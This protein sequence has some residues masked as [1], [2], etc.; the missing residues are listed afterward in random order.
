MSSA[1]LPVLLLAASLGSGYIFY[2]C[3]R[4]KFD[5]CGTAGFTDSL[6]GLRGVLATAVVVHH[7]YWGLFFDV[8]S[9]VS[10]QSFVLGIFGGE[11]V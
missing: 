6:C 3:G 5:G 1:L 2:Y 10:L 7:F 11:P 4:K 9:A 8:S